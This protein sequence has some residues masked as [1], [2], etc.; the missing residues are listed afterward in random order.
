MKI[1]IHKL[2]AINNA[3]IELGDITT[4][5]GPPNT[6]KTYALKTIYSTMLMLD[7]VARRFKLN[8]IFSKLDIMNYYLNRHNILKILDI[9]VNSHKNDI[10]EEILDKILNTELNSN[11][12]V[13]S[14]NF[15]GRDI[16]IIFNNKE[17][18]KL[19][20]ISDIIKNEIDALWNIL[21]TDA[22]TKISSNYSISDISEILYQSFNSIEKLPS[23]KHKYSDSNLKFELYYEPLINREYN[24][25][26]N[27]L[28]FK[29]RT[30]INLSLEELSNSS[31]KILKSRIFPFELDYELRRYISHLKREV[32]SPLDDTFRDI[33]RTVF[34]L[35]SILFI[36]FGRSPFTCQI[37]YISKNPLD[38][39]ELVNAYKP[40]MIYYSYLKWISRGRAL[41][42]EEK[43]KCKE[44]GELFNPVLQGNV[45]FNKETDE[46]IYKRNGVSVPIKHASALAEEVVGILLPIFTLPPN[47]CIIIE[48]PEAQLH[49]SAQ[50]LMALTL[51]SLS[52]KFGHKIVISTHSD[53]LAITLAYLKIFKPK[54]DDIINLIRELLN[55]QYINLENIALDP[56]AKELSED[57]NLNM[58]FYYHKPSPEGVM[59][60]EKCVK[61][62]IEDVPGISEVVE[63]L[64]SWSL[65]LDMREDI[66]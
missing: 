24:A 22:D 58:K 19:N 42:S 21:P 51:A 53:V 64:A 59:V 13:E 61:D 45:E 7:E 11:I 28:T 39:I 30:T 1:S 3:E 26:S 6:G 52:K 54:K 65:N 48:E 63:L 62:I 4:I 9:L 23:Y 40:N 17:C 16:Q 10:N 34:N 32:L 50:I 46:I 57:F 37:D 55:M 44:V 38:R 43:E 41:L 35:Q 66:M 56:L 60:V 20:E 8:E 33:Y 49:Y 36:P 14:I 2:G 5:I 15:K 25:D 18:I 31:S 27:I 12:E 47:S 29:N